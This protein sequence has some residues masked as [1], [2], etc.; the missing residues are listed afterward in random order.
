MHIHVRVDGVL[1]EDRTDK[2]MAVTERSA[3][4][5]EY[6]NYNCYYARE[7]GEHAPGE[8]AQAQN[9]WHTGDPRFNPQ[10]A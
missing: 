1:T 4:V 10:Y 2:L 9:V 7:R 8:T 5:C 6:P 3:E